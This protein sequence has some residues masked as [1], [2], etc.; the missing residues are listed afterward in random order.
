MGE[1][2]S[3]DREEL[4]F[5]LNVWNKKNLD[6]GCWTEDVY[7]LIGEEKRIES[8]EKQ[9]EKEGKAQGCRIL[10]LAR[11]P[12]N[13]FDGKV[14]I[15]IGPGCCGLLEMSNA[16]I[17]IAIEPLAEQ[18][19]DNNLLLQNERGAVY[20]SCSA[21]SM[22]LMSEYADIAIAA[23]CLDHVDDIGQSIAEIY[24]VLK[25]GGEVFINVEIDHPPTACE[26]HSLSYGDIVEL[27]NS[28]RTVFIVSETNNDG[29]KWV[30][31]VYEKVAF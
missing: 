7:S 13:Y 17:K 21:E 29:R 24:R 23:N 9:R 2:K 8:Y 25:I 11:K 3:K 20:L 6:T 30:R 16:R 12:R 19:R 14:V 22:P 18:F 26:P 10:S 1:L 27:F 4:D 28:F 15:E 5:W 31:A